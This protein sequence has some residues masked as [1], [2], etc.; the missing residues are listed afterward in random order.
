MPEVTTPVKN[1]S[2]NAGSNDACQERKL[3]RPEVTTPV[4]NG[5]SEAGSNDACQERKLRRPEVTTPVKN[6]SSDA[7]SNDACQ[8]RKLRRGKTHLQCRRPGLHPWVGKIPWRR[9]QLP[10][11]VLLPKESHGQRSL[12]GYSAWSHKEPNMTKLLTSRM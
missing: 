6:R 11:R 12:V 1:G 4:K 2:S 5:S 7:R 8:E 3:R 10:I 9:E